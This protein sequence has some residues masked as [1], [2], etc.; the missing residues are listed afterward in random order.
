MNFCG[1]NVIEA[2]MFFEKYIVFGSYNRKKNI[3]FLQG[4][5]ILVLLGVDTFL[6]RSVSILIFILKSSFLGK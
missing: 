2:E 3:L 6:R 5:K 4:L 1:E